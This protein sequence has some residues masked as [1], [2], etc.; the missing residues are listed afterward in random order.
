VLQHPRGVMPDFSK[1]VDA[2]QREALAAFVGSSDGAKKPAAG[3]RPD[4]R[5][6]ADCARADFACV[7]QAFG[8]LTYKDGPKRALAELQ[9]RIAADAGIAQQCHRIAHLMGSAALARYRG[10]VAQA[11]VQGSPVCASGYYHGILERA[12]AAR[13]DEPPAKVAKG[14]C[15]DPAITA[16]VF[17]RYQCLHGL[18]H[19]LMINSGYDM[20]GSLKVCDGLADDFE[21]SSCDG[22]VFMENFNTSYGTTSK[23]VRT[24]DPIYPC[25][26]VAER[27]KY[28]CY[29]LVTANLLRL[30]GYDQA[31]TAK[32]CLRSEPAW[33]TTC[34]ESFGRDV[35][36]ISNKDAGKL[37][38]SCRLAAAHEGDCIVGAA[39]EIV[40]S[41]A[42]P[43]RGG[44]FC[45]SVAEADRSRCFEGVGSVLASLQPTEDAL[46]AAC[47]KVSGRYA[48]ACRRGGGV[49]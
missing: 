17:V 32:G 46:R 47:R 15:V 45:R 49:A 19:G 1:R 25:N 39:R 33:V 38:A 28:Q 48:A 24:N 31:Q 40:N 10:K 2:A 34:F 20:P 4:S 30:T 11:F 44:A 23:Y 26:D 9:S 37:R 36:G 29:G 35:S 7:L 14:L 13:P 42:A 12:F 5:R 27:Y 21:Q 8:N 3:F 18:G 22:G 16:R 41:D 6:L 43:E